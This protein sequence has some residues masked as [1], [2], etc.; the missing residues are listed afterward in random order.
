MTRS[1]ILECMIRLIG[2][3]ERANAKHGDWAKYDQGDICKAVCDEHQEFLHAYI[4]G[5]LHGQHGQAQEL[6]QVA[7]TAIKGYF[8]LGGLDVALNHLQD[9]QPQVEPVRFEADPLEGRCCY[10]LQPV[11]SWGYG[12]PAAGQDMGGGL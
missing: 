4:S 10:C 6:L 7:A 2:E 1:D 3:I 12:D 11:Q 8:R 9:L 5:D